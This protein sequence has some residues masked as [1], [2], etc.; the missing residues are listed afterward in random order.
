MRLDHFLNRDIR[1]DLGEGFLAV[2]RE[3]EIFNSGSCLAD[4]AFVGAGADV[5]GA[6]DVRQLEKGMIGRRRLFVQDVGPIAADLAGLERGHHVGGVDDL[7]AGTV[8]DEDALFHLGETLRADHVAGLR[9]EIRVEGNVVG[10]GVNLVEVSGAFDV[11]CSS[12]F[13]VPINIVGD[14]VHAEGAGADGD[15]FSDAA[16][17]DDA[18]GF[19]EQFVTRFALPSVGARGVCVEEEVLLEG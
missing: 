5:R 14:Y 3:D 4:H 9:R 10:R 2:H 1:V 12:E 6:D 13:F 8:E 18:D 16:E 11:V 19:F 15:F 17:A 7:A